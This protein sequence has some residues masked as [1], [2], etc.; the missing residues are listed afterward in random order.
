MIFYNKSVL[1]PKSAMNETQFK[2]KLNKETLKPRQ[3]ESNEK[4]NIDGH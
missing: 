4:M 2:M 1:W 3:T